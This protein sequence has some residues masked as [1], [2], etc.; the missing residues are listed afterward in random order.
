MRI[1][2]FLWAGAGI[3]VALVFV[4][5]A[6]WQLRARRRIARGARDPADRRRGR[7]KPND[8]A[9]AVFLFF[10]T[11]VIAAGGYRIIRVQ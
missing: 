10:V 8:W 2:D 4:G 1:L 11:L 9:P 7:F 6:L 5:F 3:V